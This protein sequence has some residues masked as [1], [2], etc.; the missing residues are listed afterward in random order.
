LVRRYYE[1][2]YYSKS[3]VVL[4]QLNETWY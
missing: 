4:V 2:Y 1:D 3:I